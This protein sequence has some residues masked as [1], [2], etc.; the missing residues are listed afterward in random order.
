MAE[1]QQAHQGG[2]AAR[3]AQENARRGS[4]RRRDGADEAGRAAGHFA[5]LGAETLSTW[6]ELNQR[7]GQDLMRVSSSA[8]EESVRAASEIQQA[9]YAA[10]RD[11]QAAA[12]RWQA[13]WPEAFRD[14]VRW[15]QHA[16]EHAVGAMQDAIDLGRRNTETA[17]RS[18]DR[19]QTHSAE[20]A[21]TLE[22]TFQQGA[23]KIRDL[24]SR[25]ETARVA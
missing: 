2:D 24:Q 25:T 3:R 12:F 17:L 11:A 23:T 21:R 7:V 19:L 1:Q 4:E 20:A 10:W 16:F 9:T 15:Y 8:V 18:F 14:P 6:A 13:L 22:D 5:S